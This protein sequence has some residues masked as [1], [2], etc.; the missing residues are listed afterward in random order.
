MIPFLN[1]AGGAMTPK[2]SF[3]D[4][5]EPAVARTSNREPICERC[6]KLER[7]MRALKADIKFA[8]VPQDAR[9]FNHLPVYQLI[10]APV[11]GGSL[12]V[13]NLMLLGKL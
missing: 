11:A 13:L 9:Q 8:G 2:P 3:C 7:E 1:S 10:D 5:G 6:L 12:E 4:C